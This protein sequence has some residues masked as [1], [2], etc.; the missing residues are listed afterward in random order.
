M[1]IETLDI[2]GTAVVAGRRDAAVLVDLADVH[3]LI[4]ACFERRARGL[5]LYPE[6]LTPGFFD[7]R[8]GEAGEV[9][10]K[11][12]TYGLRLALVARASDLPEGHFREM[13][14]EEAR[15]SDFR[16][17]PEPDAG[18]AWLAA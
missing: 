2:A 12:R 1:Q 3:S 18:L 13:V 10:Q 16:I 11:L 17:F 8:S 6:N 14:G 5:L 15:G 9:L 4:E 7:L